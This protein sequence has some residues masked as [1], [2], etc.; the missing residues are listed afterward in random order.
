MVIVNAPLVGPFTGEM[1]VMS[2]PSYLNV[3]ITDWAFCPSTATWMLCPAPEPDA[4]VHLIVSPLLL[5]VKVPHLVEPRKTLI[6]EWSAPKFEPWM[7]KLPPP[8]VGPLSGKNEAIDGRVY[9]NIDAAVT[10]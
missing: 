6:T 7:V 5:T 2:G 8:T 10:D 9:V 1:A 3:S 4:T